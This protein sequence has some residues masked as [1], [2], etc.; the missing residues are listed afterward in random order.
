MHA[1]TPGSIQLEEDFD[2][3]AL[4]GKSTLQKLA[5]SK[6]EKDAKLL[7]KIPIPK[8]MKT[9]NKPEIF[10]FVKE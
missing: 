5:E 4:L 3:E 10:N 9:S 2:D 7:K 6:R 1:R 8:K